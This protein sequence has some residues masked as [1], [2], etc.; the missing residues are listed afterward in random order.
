MSLTWHILRK[1]L[2]RLRWIV[3]LWVVVIGAQYVLAELQAVLD[4]ES[5]RVFLLAVVVT[6]ALFL[7]AIACG[8]VMG[9]QGDDPI[10][11]AEAFWITRP[12]S[13][14]RLLGA[15]LLVFALFCLVPVV[16]GGPWWLYHGFDPGQFGR[17]AGQAMLSQLVLTLLVLPLAALSPTGAR[18][19]L[20][21]IIA[22]AVAGAVAISYALRDVEWQAKI[23]PGIAGSRTFVLVA[24]W[25]VAASVVVLLQYHG[26]RTRRSVVVIMVATLLGVAVLHGWTWNLRSEGS[27][28]VPPQ[29]AV[30]EGAV[31][32]GP[33]EVPLRA[34]AKSNG[35]GTSVRVI[36][37]ITN[38]P[39]P[40]GALLVALSE[41]VPETASQPWPWLGPKT[42]ARPTAEL[43][44]AS[45]PGEG[46]TLRAK[47]SHAREE[48]SVGGVHYFRTDLVFS[49]GDPGNRDFPSDLH[50]WVKG[51]ALRKMSTAE[52][53]G[54][55]GPGRSP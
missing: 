42:R 26:R 52:L 5:S 48:L 24:L 29:S 23:T 32:P 54:V 49:P 8:L 20:N 34:E 41:S 46:R 40:R 53:A 17:A 3:L 14:G 55:V 31:Q 12:I 36:E 22:S 25:L 7:P 15:K 47:V 50:E 37:V 33:L 6:G 27:A 13:P 28:A 44:V 38:D 10:C 18:F 45:R 11:D 43:Y 19:L 16:V 35:S 39:P 2:Y 1:D 51:A 4:A 9:V 30:E 21:A